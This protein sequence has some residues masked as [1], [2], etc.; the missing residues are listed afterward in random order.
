MEEENRL[1]TTPSAHT[2]PGEYDDLREEDEVWDPPRRSADALRQQIEE[3]KITFADFLR[4]LERGGV[5]DFFPVPSESCG[6][7]DQHAAID[8]HLRAVFGEEYA[9]CAQ[10]MKEAFLRT[11]HRVDALCRAGEPPKHLRIDMNTFGFWRLGGGASANVWAALTREGQSCR[12]VV[13]KVLRTEPTVNEFARFQREAD[14]VR[15]NPLPCFPT[16]IRRGAENRRHFLLMGYEEGYDLG[17]LIRHAC[18]LDVETAAVLIPQIFRI[19]YWLHH[20]GLLHR[21]LKPENLFLNKDGELKLIDHGFTKRQSGESRQVTDVKGG[22]FGTHAYIA[23]EVFS[24]G[25][26]GMASELWSCAT[27]AAMI[28]SGRVPYTGDT[29]EKTINTRLRMAN[30]ASFQR[31]VLAFPDPRGNVLYERFY[32]KYRYAL[33]TWL[34][35]DPRVRLPGKDSYEQQDTLR[36]IVEEVFRFSPYSQR[37]GMDLDV[38][39]SEDEA[40]WR[41]SRIPIA[42]ETGCQGEKGGPV[43][44]CRFR[45]P[46]DMFSALQ[47]AAQAEGIAYLQTENACASWDTDLLPS[48]PS[49][50]RKNKLLAGAAGVAGIVSITAASLAYIFS[51]NDNGAYVAPP[52]TTG[53][54]VPTSFP[55]IEHT[56]HVGPFVFERGTE[57]NMLLHILPDDPDVRIV[58][59]TQNAVR[60]LRNGNGGGNGRNGELVGWGWAMSPAQYAQICKYPIKNFTEM[61]MMRQQSQSGPFIVCPI[62]RNGQQEWHIVVVPH[63]L[64]LV[65]NGNQMQVVQKGINFPV[66]FQELNETGTDKDILEFQQNIVKAIDGGHLRVDLSQ[67]KQW[68]SPPWHTAHAWEIGTKHVVNYPARKPSQPR[69]P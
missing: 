3:E 68:L 10:T 23:P 33:A 52:Q 24:R 56:R 27:I 37:K 1:H 14:R 18:P 54:A 62:Q 46:S 47:R 25:E 43:V 45:R 44:P 51:G 36:G 22:V 65:T 35:P 55:E 63:S 58:F 49:P 21:D 20:H 28:L 15:Q 53:R 31:E 9:D 12:I 16:I 7:A 61:N 66:P 69:V 48:T 59:D 11:R 41:Q 42:M 29:P 6:T 57:G 8:A 13:A 5:A 26:V 39:L 67:A 64:H 17:K 32:E 50:L 60:I 19:L 34:H 30:D 4:W 40:S 2:P 38:F